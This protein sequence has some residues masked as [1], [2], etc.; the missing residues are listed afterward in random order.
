MGTKTI[1]PKTNNAGQIGSSSKYWNKGYFNEIHT[2]N[3]YTSTTGL[4]ANTITVTDGGIV[5]EG[6]GVDDHET[7]LTVTNPTADRIITL[8]NATGTVAL[9]SSD[10][11]GEAATVAT[12]AG[13][14]PNTA[15]TQATQPSITTMTG[16][17]TGSAN[18][19]L[20][21][22]GDGTVTSESGLTFT[23][24]VLAS[25][26]AFHTQTH[27]TICSLTMENTGNNVN[28]G[29]IIL[30]NSRVGADGQDDDLLGKITFQ[31][32][33]DGTPT[34]QI[35]G[36]IEVK[37]ADATSGQEAGKMEFKVAEF[38][39]TSATTIGLLIDGDTD[40]DGE[41]DVT[42]GAGVASTT[43]VAG[44]LVVAGTP[45]VGWHGSVTR[46]KIL[47]SDFQ[48]DD[49]GRPAMTEDDTTDERFLFSH[50]AAKL[51]ASISIPTGYKA[52]HVKIHG[53]DTG[54]T[55]TTY[56]ANIANKDVVEK[57]AATAIETEKAITNVTSSTTNYLLIEVSS[58]G[59]TDE[60]H[61]GYVTIAAV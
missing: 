36:N 39:G 4:T 13:L 46:I 56:E 57:G 45:L 22:D 8:P 23:G 54:Q 61:G 47:P 28:G 58:D 12:I 20:T 1:T 44:N 33:D 52:T 32:F 21:D 11:T 3:L 24:T 10:I 38:D 25:T 43:T 29:Q 18:E 5:F 6:S 26:A 42:I 2:N 14:A 31:G 40:E 27:A 19:I 30:K 59:A 50:G 35:Y 34:A 48:A 15:T 41:I 60:I 55:H 9:T 7:T 53:S 49:V 51:Y 37:V 17:V 16:F